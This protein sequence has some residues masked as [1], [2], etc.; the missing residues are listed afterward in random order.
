[1]QNLKYRRYFLYLDYHFSFLF[2]CFSFPALSRI[3]KVSLAAFS[4]VKI[5]TLS[6]P[7]AINSLRAGSSVKS[8]FRASVI[9]L[10]RCGSMVRAS[11]PTASG[12]D[13]TREVTTGTPHALA[14]SGGKPKPSKKLG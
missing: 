2:F 6:N 1:M 10:T 9:S 14:S 7:L 8:N 4:H 3:R 13:D 5:F 11:V 12:M